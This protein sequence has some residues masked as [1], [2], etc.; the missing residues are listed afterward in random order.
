MNTHFSSKKILK[1]EDYIPRNN[2]IKVKTEVCDIQYAPNYNLTQK[3][4][5]K[6]CLNFEKMTKRKP[7]YL[8]SLRKTGQ[9]FS[10]NFINNVI[11]RQ[12]KS[13]HPK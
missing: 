13:A 8:T 10:S 5:D 1:F 6:L 9:K 7:F 2:L 4:N 11:E 12:Y 3:R